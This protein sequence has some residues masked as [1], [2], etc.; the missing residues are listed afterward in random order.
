VGFITG[1]SFVP[2]RIERVWGS[3]TSWDWFHCNQDLIVIIDL[4]SLAP[5][6]PAAARNMLQGQVELRLSL[7]TLWK[8][9]WQMS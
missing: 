1:H 3:W 4:V 9:F 7:A 5:Q 6:G 8:R 2:E